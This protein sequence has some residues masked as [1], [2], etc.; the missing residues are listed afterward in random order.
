MPLMKGS[1]IADRRRFT[2]RAFCFKLQNKS[3]HKKVCDSLGTAVGIK[4]CFHKKQKRDLIWVINSKVWGTLAPRTIHLQLGLFAPRNMRLCDLD[5]L[6]TNM[7]TQS[8][9]C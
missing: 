6:P 8:R 2:S 9:R 5:N 3:A 4:V 7:C 1:F